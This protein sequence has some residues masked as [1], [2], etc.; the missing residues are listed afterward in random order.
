MEQHIMEIDIDEKD[1]NETNIDEKITLETSDNHVVEV[2]LSE[3]K[4]SETIMNLLTAVK[5]PSG[6]VIPL[7]QVDLDTLKP[8][9]Q[10]LKFHER[11]PEEHEK[12]RGEDKG[13]EDIG[14]W[15][16]EFISGLSREL[17]AKVTLA[18]NYL[19]VND[20]LTL[21]CKHIAC[22][23]KDMTQKERQEYFGT[24]PNQTNTTEVQNNN[25]K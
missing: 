15:D 12:F 10:Y 22:I 7:S 20:L 1:I 24:K 5:N 4:M 8:I 19:A 11:Y 23:I 14:T 25:N 17:L 9:L 18:A 21:A 3:M 2:P 6:Q 13:C 16:K